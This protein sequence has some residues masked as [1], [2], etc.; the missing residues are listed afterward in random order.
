MRS[1]TMWTMTLALCAMAAALTG[2]N[3]DPTENAAPAQVSDAVEVAAPAAEPAAAAEEMAEAPAEAPPGELAT[4]EEATAT[5]YAVD[6]EQSVLTFTGSKVTANHSGG[7]TEYSGTI[8]VPGGDFTAA[9]VRVDIDM[10][11]TYSDDA[12]LTEKLKSDWFFDVANHPAAA[13]ES[14]GIAKTD[15]GYDISGNLTLRGVTKNLTFPA[16]VT[17]E[18][19]TLTAEAEF[20]FD[21]KLF[22]VAYDGLADDVIRDN[23]LMALY[24][25]APA[26]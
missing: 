13:F 18:N 20:S 2:C 15:G 1:V 8:A 17:M 4:G 12:D 16:T 7:W 26:S 22:G 5:V 10:N 19:D 6:K 9:K 23:V 3:P 14:T 11:S 21:R 24:I 25:V